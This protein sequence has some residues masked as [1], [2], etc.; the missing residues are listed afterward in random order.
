M[1]ETV[2]ITGASRGVG[3]AT[4]KLFSRK[5][6]NV[7]IN[8]SRSVERAAEVAEVCKS[9][10][11]GVAIVQADVSSDRDC[12][13]LVD[14]TIKKFGNLDYLVNNAGTTKYAFDHSDLDALESDDF[15]NIYKTNVIGPY[16]LIKHAKPYLLQS[17]SPGIVNVASIAAVTGI[18]SSVA[19][20]ASKGALVTMTLSLARAL[21]PVRVNAVCPGFIQGEWL[22]EGLGIENYNKMKSKI[23]NTNPLGKTSTAED[24]A[25]AI[26]FFAAEQQIITG[27]TLILDGGAHLGM[28]PLSRR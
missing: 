15:L 28:T 25:Q 26:Y 24:I 7:V 6:C 19:Y 3:A 9:F 4:A 14:Q 1:R 11:H 21:G 20:A 27:E 2:L 13:K 23:E 17:K 18:G 5:G 10:G 12:Q 22:Q 16:N 8:C